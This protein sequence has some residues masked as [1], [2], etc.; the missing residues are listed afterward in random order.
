LWTVQ[1]AE[2]TAARDDADEPAE[3]PTEEART[4]YRGVLEAL[5][6]AGVPHLIGGG[7]AFAHYT[8]IRRY[9]KDMDIFLRPE[10]AEW[11]VGTLS[12][13]GFRAEIVAP[14]WLGKV[15]SEVDARRAPPPAAAGH[16]PQPYKPEGPFVDLIFSSGNGVCVVDDEWFEHAEPCEVL[17]VAVQLSPVEEMVWSKAFVLE[18]ERYDGADVAHLI[19]A[20]GRE[21]DWERVFRRFDP[22]WHVLLSHLVLFRFAYPSERAVVPRWVLRGLLGRM[23]REMESD[24]P[25]R[26]VC[27]GTLMSARQYL[28][29]VEEWGFSDARLDPDV[30]M[31]EADVALLTSSIRAEEKEGS[32]PATRRRR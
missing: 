25:D 27:Q 31:T 4:F 18:R 5:A 17:G 29:D 22:H 8:G 11:A 12:A 1:A 14:H 20:R 24:V 26:R 6:A 23:Q 7:L 32:G 15:Y 3:E 19:R 30:Q 13:A 16:R 21:L 10:H 2:E 28:V 9:T